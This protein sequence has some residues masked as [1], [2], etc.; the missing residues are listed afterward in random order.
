[1]TGIGCQV[2]PGTPML[3]VL[4]ACTVPVKVLLFTVK[5]TV[6]P[7]WTSPPTVPVIAMVWP[8]SLALITSSAVMFASSVIVALM[9]VSTL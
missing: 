5:V 9:V 2:R 3:K 6:S 8:A 7:T 1:M 4:P